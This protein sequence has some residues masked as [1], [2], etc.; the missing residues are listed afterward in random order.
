M[1]SFLLLLYILLYST[2]TF[3]QSVGS[4]EGVFDVSDLG[5]ANYSIPIKVPDGIKDMQPTITL[6]YNSH[7]GNSIMGM[8]WSLNGTSAITRMGNTL[9]HDRK[10]N[11]VNLTLSDRYALDGNRLVLTSGIYGWASSVYNT[12]L[13]S[14]RKI[15][16]IGSTG[17]GPQYFTVTDQN[18]WT[19]E[20]GSTVNS[21][22]LGQGSSVPYMWMLSKVTDQNGNYMT[23]EYWNSAGEEPLLRFIHYTGNTNTGA[24]PKTRITFLYHT[25]SDPNYTYIAGGKINQTQRLGTVLVEQRNASNTLTT[26]RTYLLNYATDTYSHLIKVT[27]SGNTLNG[28]AEELPP[29]EFGYGGSMQA[30]SVDN[31]GLIVDNGVSNQFAIGDY[32]GDG[33]SDM[34][35]F[36]T[37]INNGTNWELHLRRPAGLEA[38]QSGQLPTYPGYENQTIDAYNF[39]RNQTQ[40]V[41]FDFNGD[42]KDDFSYV[43]QFVNQYNSNQR[44]LLYL[45][46]GTSLV[47]LSNEICTRTYPVGTT[48]S[49]NDKFHYTTPFIGDFDGDGK[50]EILALN[51]KRETAGFA[52]NNWLI[53]AEYLQ[54]TES[55]TAGNY[56]NLARRLDDVPFDASY[57]STNESKLFVID[58]NGD[59]K[60]EILSIWGGH[61]QIL[62]LNV[63]FDANNKPVIGSPSFRLVS[64]NGYPT[65]W[66]QVF[67]G[68]FNGD[69]ITD[70]LT[71]ASGVGWEIG[72]GN[73]SGQIVNMQTG[74]A[75]TNADPMPTNA[76][77]KPI[78]IADFNGDGKQD[79]YENGS[80]SNA[81]IFYAK[82]NNGFTTESIN[83]STTYALASQSQF[84]IADMDGDGAA[85]F[86]LSRATQYMSFHPNENKHAI[87]S[88]KNSLGAQTSIFYSK[89]TNTALTTTS[90]YENPA[91]TY[92]YPFASKGLPLTAVSAVVADNGTSSG[93]TTYYGYK[94]IR[95]QLHGKGTM[96]F[97]RVTITDAAKNT[98]TQKNFA[99][100]ST[101]AI[102]YPVSTNTKLGTTTLNATSTRYEFYDYGNRRVFP[103]ISIDDKFDYVGN[104][105]IRE[106]FNYMAPAG[107]QPHGVL[108]GKPNSIIRRKGFTYEV[109]PGS[110]SEIEYA[111][112]VFQYPAYTAPYPAAFLQNKPVSVTSSNTRQGQPAYTRKQTFS[113]AP[114]NGLITSSVDDPG[115]TN[116]LTTTYGYDAYGN[117]TDKT[118]SGTGWAARTEHYQ[119]DATNRYVAGS[120]NTAFPNVK[121][122]SVY[123]PVTGNLTS[124]TA[125][126]GLVTSYTYD[127]FDRVKSATDNNGKVTNTSFAWAT[128][129]AYAPAGAKYYELNA[130][131]TA[132]ATYTYFDRLGRVLR[133][134]STFYSGSILYEDK[135][136]NTK[137]QLYSSTRPYLTSGT[138]LTTTYVYDTRGR[139]IQENRPEGANTIGYQISGANYVV[140]ATN[141]AGQVKKTVTDKTG[142]TVEAEDAGGKLNYTYHSNGKVN[143]VSL[144][145]SGVVSTKEYDEQAQLKK[146]TDPNYGSYEYTYNPFG[147]VI[148]KKDPK[149]NTFYF[150]YNQGGYQIQRGGPDGIFDQN[151]EYNAGLNSGKLTQ[152][153]KQGGNTQINYDYGLGDKLNYEERKSGA[154]VL[155]TQYTYDT[156]GRVATKIFPNNKG[157]AYEYDPGDGSVKTVKRTDEPI[158]KFLYTDLSKNELGQSR[159]GVYG[160]QLGVS[161]PNPLAWPKAS[162]VTQTYDAYGR[163]ASRKSQ[164]QDNTV[165]QHFEYTFQPSTGNLMQ[166]KDIKYTMQEDFTYDNLNRLKSAQGQ[167]TG[168]FPSMLA[169][170]QSDFSANGNIIKKSDAG[171]FTYDVANRVSEIE[172]YVNIP[173]VTQTLTHNSFNKVVTLEEGT[174]SANFSYWPDE[175]R[176]KMEVYENGA[177]QQTKLYAP[178]YEKITDVNGTVRELCY[179]KDQNRNIIAIVEVKNN[180]TKNYFV[181]T[182]YMGS[183]TQI[184]DESGNIVD[185]KSF[186]AWGQPRTPQNWST[187]PPTGPGNDWDRGYTGHEHMPKF[188]IINMNGRLYDPLMGRMF[189]PDPFV[190]G[191]DNT[192]GYNRYSYALNNPLKYTDP[193]GNH[194]IIIAM[195]IGAGISALTYTANVATSSAGFRN[196]NWG[197]FAVTTFIGAASGVVTYGIGSAFGPVSGNIGTELLRAGAHGV[198]GYIFAGITGSD[199][200]TGF[201]AGAVASGVG[202]LT[203]G[204]PI[205]NTVIGGTVAAA[206]LGGLSSAIG[207]GDFWKGAAFAAIVHLANQELHNDPD[208]NVKQDKALSKGEI[209]KLKRNGWDHT[210]KGNHG[211]QTDLYKDKQGNVYQKPKGGIGAGEPI[212]INLNELEMRG[213]PVTY[214]PYMGMRMYNATKTFIDNVGRGFTRMDRALFKFFCGCD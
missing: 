114:T 59:G 200:N 26:L 128:G 78:Y 116:A 150:S 8:G 138:P 46:N 160:F 73:G 93:N 148:N 210:D 102:S 107:T 68:D 122:T 161:L 72:Y 156:K 110:P 190:I 174:A 142:K 41:S 84:N 11:G 21:R 193:D 94:G 206:G 171:T 28:M 185:E 196:W 120:W 83:F 38:V 53:G 184:L 56:V 109:I 43:A 3:A 63:T 208:R 4:T 123:D 49:I 108:I 58:Y 24:T 113:Y 69:G 51:N 117:V 205:T 153:N 12:E 133:K 15:T 35:R 61:A 20:Y 170:L 96:G 144:T 13:E 17:S 191:K 119:Y 85:D 105:S 39:I 34:V 7:G 169:T 76:A 98:V 90:F 166:R 131:N 70:V 91:S 155:K 64:D 176:S 57:L 5:S 192:Q 137:G 111:E 173:T 23:Y 199:P 25:R 163:P 89:L 67:T 30:V 175:E 71:W 88:I 82:G 145:G 47:P 104:T 139:V 140:T 32:N 183:I 134:A 65:I 48:A 126:D 36:P 31:L 2:A 42:G 197:D 9:Y 14:F 162:M 195:A 164:K 152:V 50:I 198:S 92:T 151:Y 214:D 181:L 202:S 52:P 1:R 99:L 188:G 177:L 201:L 75:L 207:G 44:Y 54:L 37:Y 45:S 154:D 212:G 16:A 180:V 74:P 157:L 149:G 115:T 121:T 22:A 179:V 211:G 167:N 146:D 136:Y 132:K 79:I 186:T 187:L 135:S 203:A 29:V 194:P 129:H 55:I 130:P 127:G 189:A 112:Q 178:D 159:I 87:N 141:A 101:F 40:S 100:N 86:L 204:L 97:E 60:N 95:Y 209:E 124:N 172:P 10:V 182:D 118:E 66:H 18:G 80:G 213:L 81:K 33:L 77:H 125:P 165:Q 62:E 6:S 168:P 143:Q 147:E 19:Y 27:E 158:N 103:Y 106:Q